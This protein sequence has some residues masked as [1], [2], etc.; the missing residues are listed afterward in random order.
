MSSP[1]DLRSHLTRQIRFLQQSCKSYDEGFKDEGIRIAVI[2]RILMHETRNQRPLLR[3]L[4]AMHIN[5]TTT[6][7]GPSERAVMY[8]GFGTISFSDAGIKHSAITN[9]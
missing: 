8:S 1:T 5:L 9:V 4:D 3:N 2:I 7:S 6:C